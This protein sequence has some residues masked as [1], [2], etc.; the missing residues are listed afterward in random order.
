MPENRSFEEC[1]ARLNEI[2]AKLSSSEVTLDQS[3]ELYKEAIDLSA[4]CKKKL[5]EA[6]LSI[7][8]FSKGTS[9]G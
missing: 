5:E 8:T 9:N 6:K 3:L 7:E 2:N 4:Y 1:L